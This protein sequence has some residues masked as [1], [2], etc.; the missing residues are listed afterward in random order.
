MFGALFAL[1]V[2]ELLMNQYSGISVYAICGMVAVMS[3]VIGAPMTA[4]LL[5]F[6]FTR[7]YEITVAAMVAIVFANL[8][9]YNW[10]GRSL[11]DTMLAERGIDLSM[12]RERAYL[13]HHKVVEY[14][15]DLLPV[16]QLST[17]LAQLRE[18]MVAS[19]S[20]SSV[21]VDSDNRYQGKVYSASATCA[22]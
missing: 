16:V 20:S 21:I 14:A 15:T 2:P 18:Q 11:Y 6:E 17:S 5:V 12:G 9:A 8:V 22:G 13:M 4:L 3:P 10:F 19:S 7:N 1:L